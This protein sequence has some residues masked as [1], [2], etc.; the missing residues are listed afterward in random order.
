MK[1]N[2]ILNCNAIYLNITNEVD[3]IVSEYLNKKIVNIK[4]DIKIKQ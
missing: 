3:N 4:Y 2:E 1:Y